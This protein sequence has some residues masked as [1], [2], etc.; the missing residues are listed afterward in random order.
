[1]TKSKIAFLEN[2]T[3]RQFR[4]ASL[5]ENENQ[6]YIEKYDTLTKSEILEGL[7]KK[8]FEIDS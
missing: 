1:M 4:V 6:S 5:E 2:Q 3:P 7:P 8:K